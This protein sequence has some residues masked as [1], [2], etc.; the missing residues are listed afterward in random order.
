MGKSVG[1]ERL[2]P[3]SFEGRSDNERGGFADQFA[4]ER[5]TTPALT[6]DSLSVE[7]SVGSV[8]RRD[9]GIRDPD[10][11]DGSVRRIVIGEDDGIPTADNSP[12]TV[13]TSE[14]L[15]KLGQQPADSAKRLWER[16][17][18][19]GEVGSIGESSVD[20]LETGDE[21]GGSIAEGSRIEGGDNQGVREG[22][23]ERRNRRKKSRK[24][25]K[26]GDNAIRRES[27]TEGEQ[28]ATGKERERLMTKMSQVE[29]VESLEDMI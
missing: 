15:V 19:A 25:K 7:D 1:V 3:F 21:E 26:K 29:S 18:R 8:A 17:E 12:V 11:S 4:N 9:Q 13:I 14:N 2:R 10:G 6:N 5:T 24:R 27:E 28:S 22:L 23:K 20:T 16:I